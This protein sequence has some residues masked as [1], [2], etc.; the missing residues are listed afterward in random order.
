MTARAGWARPWAWAAAGS[1]AVSP[2]ASAA[3]VR[4]AVVW[5]VRM[6]GSS[7]GVRGVG[8]YVRRI[9]WPDDGAALAALHG[10]SDPEAAAV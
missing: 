8:W 2:R 10:S 5:A 1:A 9:V 3:A 7:R 6:A 4:Q